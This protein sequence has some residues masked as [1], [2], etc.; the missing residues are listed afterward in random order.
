MPRHPDI[1]S[2]CSVIRIIL[3]YRCLLVVVVHVCLV[4]LANYLA[5]WLRFDG[6]VP[7]AWMALWRQTLPWLV[8]IRGLTFVPF[9]LYEGLWRY[10]SIWDL[11]SIVASV[12]GGHP[13]L[14]Y[15]GLLGL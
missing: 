7:A 1:T 6:T 9:R 15:A 10:T 4:V 2:E 8:A 13:A 14:R 12:G 5:F 11:R 3:K